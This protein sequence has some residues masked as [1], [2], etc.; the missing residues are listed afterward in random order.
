MKGDAAVRWPERVD[1]TF[2]CGLRVIV[3]WNGRWELGIWRLDRLPSDNELADCKR[4]FGV[5]ERVRERTKMRMNHW[6]G[7]VYIWDGP[8]V[9]TEE[10]RY[11]FP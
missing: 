8:R 6:N 7:Y 2:L 10:F 3:R 11:V 4:A 1:Y 5:P 9:E